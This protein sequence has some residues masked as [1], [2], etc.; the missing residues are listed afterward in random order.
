[1]PSKVRTALTTAAATLLALSAGG[2]RAVI[3]M[4]TISVER[5][6]SPSRLASRLH[7]AREHVTMA[8]D[9]RTRCPQ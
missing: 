5:T 9:D 6:R 7:A 4:R 2:L 1:M 3:G 8:V